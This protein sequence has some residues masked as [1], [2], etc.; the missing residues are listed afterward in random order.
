[1]K[2]LVSLRCQNCGAALTID[3]NS[4]KCTCKFCNSIFDVESAFPDK[5]NFVIHAGVLEKYTGISTDVNIPDGVLVIGKQCF[6]GKDT[7]KSVLLPNGLTK[8]DDEAFYGCTSLNQIDFPESL[9]EIGQAA[10]RNSSVEYVDLSQI[11]NIGKDAFME[12]TSLKRAI[13]PKGKNMIY[14]RAFKQCTSLNEV[15][16]DLADFCLSFKPSNEARKNG[17]TRSTLFDTFQATPYF[18]Q[19]KTE[20]Q[21]KKCLQCGQKLTKPQCDHCGANYPDLAGGCYIATKVYGSYD[22]PQ[23]WTL[24]RYR[25]HALATTWYG[26]AFIRAYYAISPTVVKWFGRAEWFKRICKN[27]LDKLVTK[28]Q[29]IGFDATPYEDKSW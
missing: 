18:L 9:R 3:N 28:L 27:K 19:L 12:C 22:C 4:N 26:R 13:L 2:Q 10:F 5:D 24:R 29:A 11:S 17:D 6:Q 1:M 21:E 7:I 16:C 14:N 20:F 23:V 15:D 8:I 25:D